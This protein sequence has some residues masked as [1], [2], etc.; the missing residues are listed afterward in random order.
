MVT[1]LDL[2]ELQLLVAA[3]EQLPVTQDSL[4]LMVLCCWHVS[5]HILFFT[6]C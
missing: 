4:H 1:G 5:Q 2:V 3:G 6:G